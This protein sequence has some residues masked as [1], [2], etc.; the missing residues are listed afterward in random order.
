MRRGVKYSLSL[1]LSSVTSNWYPVFL[2][3]VTSN[4]YPVFLFVLNFINLHIQTHHS[5]VMMEHAIIFLF[6]SIAIVNIAS[7]FSMSNQKRVVLIGGGHAQLQVIKAFNAAARPANWNITLIDKLDK[8]TYSGMVPGCVAQ[9]YSKDETQID[10]S[11]LSSWAGVNFCRGTVVDLH[12]ESNLIFLQDGSIIN[13]DVL[14]IDIG[15]SVRGLNDVKG[16]KEYAI[17]T[18]PIDLLINRVDEKAMEIQK[19]GIKSVHIIVVGAGAAGIEMSMVLKHRFGKI[20]DR[21]SVTVLNSGHEILVGESEECKQAMM[22][23]LKANEIIL[24][25]GCRVK[26]VSKDYVELESGESI[27]CSFCVWATGAAAHDLSHSL[28]R[29]GLK[30]STDGWI[31]V[32][33]SL[34]STSHENIFAAGDCATIQF[35]DGRYSPPKAGVYAVRSGPVL[36]ENISR[37]LKEESLI[38]FDPQD[39]FLKLFACGDGTA[40][41]FRFGI[42]FRGP[43]VFQLKDTIDR[44]FMDLFQVKKLPD[45]NQIKKGDYDTHQY[46]ANQHLDEKMEPSDAAA[47]LQRTDDGVDFR[48]A[49]SVLRNMMMDHEYR[50]LVLNRH[51]PKC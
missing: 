18:R 5:V 44:M 36:I 22:N 37:Y 40:V 15:S 27:S 35:E 24:R 10:L 51:D 6:W 29:N 33:D 11:G 7:A 42:A 50:K 25:N 3:S 9:Y 43:W 48:Q 4:W 28:K 32:N 39:D 41:G 13:Y 2:S 21:V 34:Q 38:S 8:A 20:T 45:M 26:S 17:A 19:Q 49:W 46:D 12:P 30:M 31:Q 23:L 14:S 47:L 1:T 16:V